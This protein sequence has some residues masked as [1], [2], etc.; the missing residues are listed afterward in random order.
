MTA[1]ITVPQYK[2]MLDQDIFFKNFF[3]KFLGIW[4]DTGLTWNKHV[5]YI[6]KKISS[7]LFAI[8]ALNK[9]FTKN[10]LKTVYFSLVESHLTYGILFWDNTYKKIIKPLIIQQR[11]AIC[12][13]N[14][15]KYKSNITDYL[16]AL[17]IL[18]INDLY[19]YS[20]D[21]F[22]YKYTKGE[23]PVL[24]YRLLN[25]NI[26]VHNHNINTRSRGNFYVTK[27]KSSCV[28]DSFMVK[29][30]KFWNGCAIVLKINSV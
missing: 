2:Y 8:R 23:L 30:P 19:L 14:K 29:G 15:R 12:I 26:Y 24:L 28:M 13:I 16:F 22:M 11:R 9:L 5:E 6:A 21:R 17:K 20:L 18:N 7:S 1:I 25:L 27:Y 3:L 10:V 4:I